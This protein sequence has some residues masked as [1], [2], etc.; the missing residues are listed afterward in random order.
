MNK[1]FVVYINPRITNT[2]AEAG[3]REGR[4]RG[5]ISEE[6]SKKTQL[7]VTTTAIMTLMIVD[8]ERTWVNEKV[9][10]STT[11]TN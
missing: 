4:A 7:R 6:T 10:K 1:D 2:K 3:R 8:D 11:A 5:N 9:N